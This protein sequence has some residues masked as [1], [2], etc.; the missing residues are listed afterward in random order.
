MGLNILITGGSGLIA[1]AI[2]THMGWSKSNHN[3]SNPSRDMLDVTDAA[4]CL[5]IIDRLRPDVVIHCAGYTSMDRA[6]DNPDQCFLVNASGTENIAA[7]CSE[8]DIP[9][10]YFSSDAVFDGSKSTPYTTEDQPNPISVYGK[11]KLAGEVAIKRHLSKYWILRTT[12]VYGEGRSNFITNALEADKVGVIRQLSAPTYV[13]DLV[14]VVEN[15]IDKKSYGLYHYT[16]E[17]VTSRREVVEY[18]SK[19]LNKPIEAYIW[20][21]QALRP[22]N[23]CLKDNTPGPNRPWKEALKEFVIGRSDPGPSA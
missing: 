19:L 15:L 11:S 21:G 4:H 12:W 3:I 5:K 16:N 2:K 9:V 7:A 18:I 17:G 23:A 14:K 13:N 8:F 22:Y 20:T 1:S 10:F 6:E